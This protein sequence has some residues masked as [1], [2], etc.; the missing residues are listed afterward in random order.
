MTLKQGWRHYAR[1]GLTL[2]FRSI[3]PCRANFVGLIFVLS[4]L[5]SAFSL[6]FKRC[7]AHCAHVTLI[8]HIPYPHHA[9]P[10]KVPETESFP[11]DLCYTSAC[12]GLSR[13]Q[14]QPSGSLII[15]KQPT[16]CREGTSITQILFAA[17]L[18]IR[19]ASLRV[20][21]YLCISEPAAS[22]YKFYDVCIYDC[23]FVV[24]WCTVHVVFDSFHKLLRRERSKHLISRYAKNL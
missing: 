15:G 9:S 20:V 11:N 19:A 17:E 22:G 1:K 3:I 13:D 2:V 8:P 7:N 18:H 6:C 14:Y 23:R 10:V 16:T 4:P 24:I 5:Y 21:C 12:H